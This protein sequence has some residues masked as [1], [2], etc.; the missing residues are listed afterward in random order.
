M[1]HL[2][3]Y[4]MRIKKDNSTSSGIYH[5]LFLFSNNFINVQ[6]FIIKLAT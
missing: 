4:I 5:A 3:V 2:I 1:I 6:S